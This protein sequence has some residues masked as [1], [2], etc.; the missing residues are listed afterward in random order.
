MNRQNL[1]KNEFLAANRVEKG[2]KFHNIRMKH[3]G[4][5]ICYSL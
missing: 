5:A 2:R 3:F 4:I 1:K